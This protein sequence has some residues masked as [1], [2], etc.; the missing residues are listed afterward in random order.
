MNAYKDRIAETERVKERKRA[1]V[2]RGAGEVPVVPDNRYDEQVAVRHADASGADITENQHEE[3]RIRC[4]HV[5]KRGSEAAGQ[6]HP[7]KL[8][9][10]IDLSKKLRVHQRLPIQLLLWNIL[11]AVRHKV[12]RGP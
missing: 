11:R 1:R 4:I 2:E 10:A 5:G 12:G 7:D 3:D 9:K 6:D 8:R